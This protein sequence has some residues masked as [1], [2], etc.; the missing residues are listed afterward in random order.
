MSD[1]IYNPLLAIKQGLILPFV[2][3]ARKKG[4]SEEDITKAAII[5]IRKKIEN[6][7]ELVKKAEQTLEKYRQKG[8]TH[9]YNI[10][11]KE[12]QEYKKWLGDAERAF[13]ILNEGYEISY[14]S[15]TINP[16]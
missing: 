5:G 16:L 8:N 11:S 13:G 7:E 1:E 14:Q 12:I 2:R 10:R 4:Y 6:Y 9:Y 3:N 15:E